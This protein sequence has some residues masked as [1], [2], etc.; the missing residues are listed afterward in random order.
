MVAGNLIP[1]KAKPLPHE[2]ASALVYATHARGF[3][4]VH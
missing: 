4:A 2:G 3:T 1:A